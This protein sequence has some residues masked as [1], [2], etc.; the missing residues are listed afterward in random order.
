MQTTGGICF[1]R[2]VVV[3]CDQKQ[4]ISFKAAELEMWLDEIQVCGYRASSK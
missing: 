4:D 2:I 3:A 1:C